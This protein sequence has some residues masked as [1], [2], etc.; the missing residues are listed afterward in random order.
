[1]NNVKAQ[2]AKV[3]QKSVAKED[4]EAVVGKTDVAVFKTEKVGKVT[5]ETTGDFQLYDAATKTLYPADEQVD[6]PE[7]DMFVQKNIERGKLK[8]VS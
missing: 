8:K 1:M 6:R 4:L 3:T 5:V 7:N 2:Q